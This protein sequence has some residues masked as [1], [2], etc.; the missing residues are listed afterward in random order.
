MEEAT[1][2]AQKVLTT[3]SPS[4]N[5][6]VSPSSVLSSIPT[7]CAGLTPYER[8]DAIFTIAAE[9]SIANRVLFQSFGRIVFWRCW[10]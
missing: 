1:T 8:E 6:S 9:L 4:I 2:K 7:L 3:F 5:P 10:L